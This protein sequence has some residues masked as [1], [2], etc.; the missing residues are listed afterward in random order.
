MTDSERWCPIPGYEGWYE[1]SSFG[2][3]RRILGCRGATAGRILRQHFAGGYPALSLYRNDRKTKFQ[4]HVLVATAFY[5]PRP[6]GYHVNHKDTDKSNNRADNLEWITPAANVQHA[7]AHGL[8]G[9]R[10][11]PGEAN[12]RAKLGAASVEEIRRLKG[13]LGARMIAK[14]FGVSRSA[15]QLI[16]QGKSWR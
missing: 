8:H 15:V 9:G 12:G 3:V 2:R 7:L 11:L 13:R 16:H 14:R 6:P 10:P 1:V 4:V 5:G